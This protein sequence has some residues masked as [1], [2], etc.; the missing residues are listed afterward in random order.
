[1]L[2][3]VGLLSLQ[4]SNLELQLVVLVLLV[5]VGLLHVVLGLK[6]VIGEVLADLLG[7]AS[8]S[9]VQSFL[10]RSQDLDLLFVKVE[11]LLKGA[12]GLFQAINL[13][14][15]GRSECASSHLSS[16]AHRLIG[17]VHF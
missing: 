1:M 4:G 9:V 17:I 8:H 5:K 6:H 2:L 15:E 14:L 10:L 11:L 7:F 13:S 3:Q 12:D 16:S